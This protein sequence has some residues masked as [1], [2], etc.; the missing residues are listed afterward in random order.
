MHNNTEKPA[1]S[2]KADDLRGL[3]KAVEEHLTTVHLVAQK[4]NFSRDEADQW[5]LG[6]EKLGTSGHRARQWEAEI[7]PITELT[8]IRERAA[9]IALEKAEKIIKGL[10]RE[11]KRQN[12]L[13]CHLEN[14]LI[15]VKT[16]WPGYAL[17]LM[18][19]TRKTLEKIAESLEVTI[20]LVKKEKIRNLL[21]RGIIDLDLDVYE[22]R[23]LQ[24][25]YNKATDNPNREVLRF[26]SWNDFYRA[27]GVKEYIS[28]TGKV[29]LDRHDKIK[30]HKAILQLRDKNFDVVLRIRTGYDKRTKSCR[31]TVIAARE[32][33]FKLNL[34]YENVADGKMSNV[35]GNIQ[36]PGSTAN[37]SE[38]VVRPNRWFLQ[39]PK[40]VRW[41]NSSLYHELREAVGP[42]KRVS[43]YD[44]KFL[45][46]LHRHKPGRNPI[47]T[48]IKA[49]AEELGMDEFIKRKRWGRVG[50]TLLRAYGIAYE[51]G[52]LDQPAG[53]K[54]PAT[55]GKTKEVF[56][57]NPLKIVQS[58]SKKKM[59]LPKSITR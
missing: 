6:W 44:F 31:Y 27:C 3:L 48:N 14:K 34:I 39:N 45:L 24:G 26:K 29:E 28:T 54:V 20:D 43:K 4:K 17:D 18:F 30:I 9:G 58:S 1:L 42:G 11:V 22:L 33:L 2:F 50:K 36:A 19:T 53:H 46:W 41:I 15:P 57:L 7:G 10:Q 38:I 55:R 8:E 16:A 35:M 32:P 40:Y 47:E 23:V 13:I 21:A 37:L 51:I 25:I 56:Y 5:L 49:L 52:Y 59:K 12:A